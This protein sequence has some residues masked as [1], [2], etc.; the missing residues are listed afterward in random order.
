[1]QTFKRWDVLHGSKLEGKHS[2]SHDS[3]VAT[4]ASWRLPESTSMLH[5]TFFSSL[6]DICFAD[7]LSSSSGQ[8]Q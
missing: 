3:G 5:S 4:V 7:D 8:M 1:M 6:I 2:L